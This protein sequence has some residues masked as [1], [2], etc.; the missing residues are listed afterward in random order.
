MSNT[1]NLPSD[2]GWQGSNYLAL[3]VNVVQNYDNATNKSTLT[4]KLQG[5]LPTSRQYNDTFSLWG[6]NGTS[7]T[8][9]CNGTTLVTFPSSGSST[10]TVAVN[11]DQ[12]WRDVLH[13]GSALSW[14]VTVSHNLDGSASVPF[15]L[16]AY[17]QSQSGVS[18]YNTSFSSKSAA[19]TL[20]GTPSQ[21]P[22]IGTPTA[23]VV[24]LT[25]NF[26]NNYIAG[27]TKVKVRATVTPYNTATISSVKLSYA[28]GT[29]VNMTLNNGAYEATTAQPITGNTTFTV[30]ATDSNG[31]TA[32]KT[33]SVTGVVPYTAPSITIDPDYTYRCDS[34][35]TK[36]DGGT[37]YKVKATANYYSSLSGNSITTFNVK[38]GSG[39]ATALTSGTQSGAISGMTDPTKRYTITLTVQ[40]KVSA[41]VTRTYVLEGM[42][43]NVVIRRSSGGTY[44]GVGTTPARS[45]GVSDIEL[46]IGGEIFIGAL[47]LTG[48]GSV[49][50]TTTNTNP[51]GE[52]GGTWAAVSQSAIPGLYFWKR[53]A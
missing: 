36:T 30:T 27:Y 4:I 19:L 20:T 53:T 7:G 52:L 23:S 12:A 5:R 39:T 34:G 43:R 47:S 37:Y 28:G 33:V 50:I 45:S 40:D 11:T 41:A 25:G 22:T 48:V 8:F 29:T 32:S 44:V 31:Q 16:D 2:S 42:T 6:L 49:V 46:P 24:D 15:V 1:Y 10:Y 51:Q 9:K 18:S 35:G 38:I 14:T 26:P 17:A 21:P 3:R 13:G